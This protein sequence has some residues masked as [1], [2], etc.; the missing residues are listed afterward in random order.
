MRNNLQIFKIL[1]TKTT[2][3]KQ[4]TGICAPAALVL[5]IRISYLF[6]ASSFVFRIYMTVSKSIR[7]NARIAY[8][9][10]PVISSAP[11]H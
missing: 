6:R 5:R 8:T 9:H 4:L 10:I 7:R 3:K 2:T 1:M 11:M